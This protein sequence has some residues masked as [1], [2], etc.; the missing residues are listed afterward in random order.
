MANTNGTIPKIDFAGLDPAAG[1]GQAL[2]ATTRAAVMDALRAHGCFEATM[3]GLVAPELQAAVLGPGGAVQSVYSLPA[4]TKARNADRSFR[5]FINT[6]PRLAYESFGIDNPLSLDAVRT[7]ADLMWPG[8]GNPDFCDSVHAYA[9]KLAVLE[10]MVRRMVLESLGATAESLEELAKSMVLHLRQSVY[11][12]VNVEGGRLG[13][14]S[15]RDFGFLAVISQND[16]DGLEVE[17]SRGN[18]GWARPL[19]S[20]RSFLVIAGDVLRVL[21]NGKVHSPRHHVVMAGDQDRYTSI[22][23]SYPTHSSVVRPM[24]EAV[25]AGQSALFR[26]FEYGQYCKFVFDPENRELAEKLEAFAA[27]SVK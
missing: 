10:G 9:E 25:D 26:P 21:T 7:F 18:D 5:G 20:K 16:V 22:I 4:S 6:M 27:V 24:Q 3:D 17:C 13:L 11:A 1:A 2:W 23:S 12:A 14:T 8:S 15:H 19:L